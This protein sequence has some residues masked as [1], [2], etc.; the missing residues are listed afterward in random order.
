M[1]NWPSIHQ[2][3]LPNGDMMFYGRELMSFYPGSQHTRS[4]EFR[5]PLL[6]GTNQ[7]AS[8]L[9]VV[10]ATVSLPIQ[11]QHYRLSGTRTGPHRHLGRLSSDRSSR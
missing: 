3:K 9:P 1:A 11:A 5:V 7:D 4:A 6:M 8:S 2:T 10:Q